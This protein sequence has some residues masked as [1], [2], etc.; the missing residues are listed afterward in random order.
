LPGFRTFLQSGLVLQANSSTVVNPVLN[1]G[2]VS[3]TAEVQAKASLVETRSPGIG[4]VVENTR[5][6]ELPLIGRQV[7]DL[8]GVIGAALPVLTT[9]TTFRGSYPN[10]T[11]LS[12]AGGA[13][14]GNSYTIHD[15]VHNGVDPNDGV[16]LPCP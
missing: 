7:T 14:G 10:T 6:L 13:I 9:D 1:F 8:V 15:G 12:I 16:P 4:Q 2:Q 5:I 3:E 11:A